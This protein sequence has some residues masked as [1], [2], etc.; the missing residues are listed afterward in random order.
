MECKKLSKNTWKSAKHIERCI[1]PIPSTF[2]AIYFHG[3]NYKGRL[4][5]WSMVSEVCSI[6]ISA[7]KLRVKVDGY[8]RNYIG[9]IDQSGK[10][11]GHGMASSKGYEY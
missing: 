3:Y 5:S 9:E 1:W 6:K 2:T 11:C 4:V 10:A 8:I 7:G